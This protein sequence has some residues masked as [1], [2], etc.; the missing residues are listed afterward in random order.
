MNLFAW[1]RNLFERFDGEFSERLKEVAQNDAISQGPPSR[2]ACYNTLWFTSQLLYHQ[3]GRFA[4][5][6]ADRLAC[7]PPGKET[8]RFRIVD[9]PI[10]TKSEARAQG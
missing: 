6:N 10:V 7:P 2:D 4:T 5:V 8:A 1:M 3:S 9:K